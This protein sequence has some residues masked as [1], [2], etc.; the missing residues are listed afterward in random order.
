MGF[1]NVETKRSAVEG[2]QAGRNVPRMA[3]TDLGKGVYMSKGQKMVCRDVIFGR[4][5]S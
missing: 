1:L 2:I 3:V 4:R 5:H